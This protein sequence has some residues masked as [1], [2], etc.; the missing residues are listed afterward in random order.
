MNTNMNFGG[1]WT[2]SEWTSRARAVA[3]PTA[4]TTD[5]ERA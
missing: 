3:Y 4:A 1:R 5:D 2:A